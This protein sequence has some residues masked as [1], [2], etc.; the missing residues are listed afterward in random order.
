MKTP[1][2][3]VHI[4][5]KEFKYRIGSDGVKITCPDGKS[6]FYL[7]TEVYPGINVYYINPHNF[8]VEPQEI[9]DFIELKSGLI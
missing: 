6:H 9:K 8:R 7:W 3:R 1:I 4:F 2:K 5:G